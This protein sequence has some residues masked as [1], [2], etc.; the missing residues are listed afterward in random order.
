MTLSAPKPPPPPASDSIKNISDRYSRGERLAHAQDV[1]ARRTLNFVLTLLGKAITPEVVDLATL[2]PEQRWMESRGSRRFP[3]EGPSLESLL[4]KVESAIKERVAPKIL[5]KEWQAMD[6][7]IATQLAAVL[8]MFA[9]D[10]KNQDAVV[11]AKAAA[12]LADRKVAELKSE[13]EL[14]DAAAARK[15]DQDELVK[16]AARLGVQ[17]PV[18]TPELK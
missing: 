3:S 5:T 9:Q 1:A 10:E 16:L 4:P 8:S 17:I 14:R 12:L 6:T 15:K 18:P 2:S 7:Q 13:R 11:K